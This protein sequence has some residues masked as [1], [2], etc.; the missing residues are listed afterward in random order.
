MATL[1]RYGEPLGDDD[2]RDRP[3]PSQNEQPP[4]RGHRCSHGRPIAADGTCCP[5]H[6]RA[7]LRL[8]QRTPLATRH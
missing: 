8:E 1:D 5:A 7:R 2:N 3:S 6:D 4:A